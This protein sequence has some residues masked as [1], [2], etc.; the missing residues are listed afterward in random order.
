MIAIIN[1]NSGSIASFP[2]DIIYQS[3]CFPVGNVP[4]IKRIVSILQDSDIFEIR[5][6]QSDRTNDIKATL[7]GKKNISYYNELAEAVADLPEAIYLNATCYFSPNDLKKLINSNAK[8]CALTKAVSRFETALDGFGV[9]VISDKITDIY[10]HAR[11]HYVDYLLAGIYKIPSTYW[12]HLLS[13][14]L[15]VTRI[16]SGTMPP[17]SFF[18]ENFLQTAISRGEYMKAIASD[19]S[20]IDITM[21]FNL[22]EANT[23]EAEKY[24]YKNNLNAK[25][26]KSCKIN[27]LVMSGKNVVIENNVI[28]NGNCF[29]GDNTIIKNGVILEGNNLIGS[30]TVISN[31][32]KINH[33]TVIGNYCKV[34]FNAEIGGLMMDGASA[35]HN[36]EITGI[37]GRYVDIAAQ[38][39]SGILRFDN[40][41][42]PVI[43][44]SK[45]YE[46]LFTNVVFIGDYTRLGINNILYPGIR[47]GAYCAIGPGAILEKDIPHNTLVK[48]T[49]E[50][51]LKPWNIERYGWK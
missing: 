18:F 36:S 35:V 17:Q 16:V 34:G 12:N 3:A 13:T 19:D 10:G 27:G 21:P 37:I 48:V 33:N 42:S 44:N 9:R 5:I 1:T 38:C 24:P 11:S 51:E 30:N 7:Y 25:I 28:I 41:L 45:K 50:K 39:V 26:D 47:I 14:P 40:K 32:A 22:L 49:Q 8:A 15:G 6:I 20:V 4:N 2:Y 31:Y 43:I 29:I 46:S 23:I